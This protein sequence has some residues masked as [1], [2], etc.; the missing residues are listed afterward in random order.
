MTTPYLHHVFPIPVLQVSI[1]PAGEP[2]R[3]GPFEAIID[4]GADMAVLPLSLIRRVKAHPVGQGRIRGLWGD[5]HPVAFF[6][7]EL[8]IQDARLPGVQVAGDEA[9]R[10]IIL[11][12]NVLNNL[13]LFLDGPQRQTDVLD[14]A[15][16]RWLRDR[17]KQE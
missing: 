10:E 17:R 9:S 5:A 4:S 1:G 2:P 6:L 15:A 8:Q 14:D 12:R 13:P 3:L 11:G 7:V 16:T